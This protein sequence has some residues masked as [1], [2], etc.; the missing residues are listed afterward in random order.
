MEGGDRSG[1]CNL[2]MNSSKNG[3]SR[4]PEHLGCKLEADLD[5]AQMR[6]V[7]FKVEGG[8]RSQFS[9]KD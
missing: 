4:R 8:H 6:V 7:Y 1:F 9:P 3:V 2:H 5:F